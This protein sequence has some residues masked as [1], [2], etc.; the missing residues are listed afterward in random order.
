MV[1][2]P[3][4][5]GTGV[6]NDAFLRTPSKSTSPT[7]R[8]SPRRGTPRKPKCSFAASL[9]PRLPCVPL[10][11]TGITT[12]RV[13]IVS[14]GLSEQKSEETAAIVR[15]RIFGRGLARDKAALRLVVQHR[16]ELGAVIGFFAQRLV[17]DDD[18]GSRQC[19]RRDAIEHL[20]RNR[21]AIER[22]LWAV[23]VF[24][25]DH[26]PAQTRAVRRH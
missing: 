19:S 26:R 6:M 9:R 23:L 11:L 3:T 24:D 14:R 18:R 25:R 2:G 15:D 17:R 20:L 21:D 4:P 22:A 1:I 16:D 10:A 12:A 7:S 5:L 13:R 8:P